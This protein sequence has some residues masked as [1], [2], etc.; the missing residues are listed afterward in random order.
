MRT[1]Y[2]IAGL[3]LVVFVVLVSGTLDGWARSGGAASQVKWVIE[4]SGPRSTDKAVPIPDPFFG[5]TEADYSFELGPNCVNEGWVTVDR[6]AQTHE[7]WHV[8][9]F[10]LLGGGMSGFLAPLEGTKSM[11]CGTQGDPSDMILCSYQA[12]P[13]YGNNWNQSFCSPCVS[14]D[15]GNDVTLDFLAYWDSEPGYDA[16]SIDFEYCMSFDWIDWYGGVGVYD[17]PPAGPITESVMIPDTLHQGIPFRIRWQF[18]SDGAWS[19]EDGLWNT[20]GAITIDVVSLSAGGVYLAGPE[21]FEGAPLN[22]TGWNGWVSCNE[23]GYGDFAYLYPGLSVVQED[24]CYKDLTCLWTFYTGSTYDYSCGGWPAQMA[25]PYGPS[26]GQ[27]IWNEIW[28]P[29]IPIYVGH[30]HEL[31]KL[32]FDVYRDLKLGPLVFYVWHIRAVHPDTGC[33]LPWRDEGLVYYGNGEDWFHHVIDISHLVPWFPGGFDVNIALGVIDMCPVW[34]SVYGNCI[35]HSH[36][37]LFDNVLLTGYGSGNMWSVRDVDLFQDNFS[38]DGTITGTARADAAIDIL[39]ATSAGILPGDSVAVTVADPMRG[40]ASNYGRAAVYAWLDV[41]GPNGN[42]MGDALVDDPRYNVIGTGMIGGR[43]WT[44]IQM[45]STR[46]DRGGVVPDRFN[47]DLNDNLFVP[48]DT[49]WYFFGAMDNAN[50]WRYFS[51]SVPTLD[52]ET[53]DLGVAAANPMEFTILPAGG[54][55]RGGDILYVDGMNYRGA[56]P[57]FDSAFEFLNID[58][59]VDRYDINGPTSCVGN[60]PGARVTDVLG[61]LVPVY[62]KI[63]WDCGDLQTAISDGSPIPDKSDD[64]QMLLTFLESLPF[65]GGVYLDGDDVAS[66]M[67]VSLQSLISYTLVSRDHKATGVG[68]SPYVFGTAGGIFSDVLGPDTLVAYGGCPASNDFDVITPSGSGAV[69]AATY[70]GN[71]QTRGAIVADTTLNSVGGI[72]GFVLS[73]FGF[74]NIREARPGPYPARA[75]HMWRILTYLQNTVDEPTGA[76]AVVGVNSLSQNYP[77][78]FNPT[79]TIKYTIAQRSRVSLRIYNVAGQLVRTLVDQM[80]TPDAVRPV[81]WNGL[82]ESGQ[83]VASGVYFYKLVTNNFSQTKKMVALK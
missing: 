3:V 58:H 28:S 48:G 65:P 24:P 9:D 10:A 17:T 64:I 81:T 7:F 26:R 57:Y 23:A 51:L 59:L 40:L 47:I 13:G 62:R 79:T 4:Q 6:T 66:T 67:E 30:G 12:V 70:R 61:Q 80:Q 69:Q 31:E 32:R 42:V 15:A 8:D 18:E 19:D 74:Q 49:I 53:A 75:E 22:A 27:Y 29:N 21:N 43:I 39:P 16:T 37:P 50:D 35:C 82:D 5:Q 63:L 72:V 25:V 55:N 44:Q 11:W 77:N 78:P 34:N 14:T 45:D 54:Y 33:P 76:P 38:A 46:T 68:I 2:A 73:G 52:A 71:G 56:Q 60:H 41:D 36:A 20:D 1:K 83:P